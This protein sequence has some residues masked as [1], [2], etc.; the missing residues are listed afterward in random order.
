MHG[1]YPGPVDTDMAKGVDLPKTPASEV[2]GVTLDGV[3]AGQ[4]YIFPDPMAKQVYQ[5]W[6]ADHAAVEAQ[7][8]SM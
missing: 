6:R 4:E 5:G 2:A 8:G 1:T 3:E 7:F